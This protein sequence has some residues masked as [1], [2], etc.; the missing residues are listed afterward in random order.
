MSTKLWGGRFTGA[1]DPLME[2][3]NASILFDRRLWQADIRGSQAYA[4]ALA[5]AG[6]LTHVEAAEIVAGLEQ[7]A[8]EWEA[9]E[10]TL[11]PQDEDIHTANERRLTELIGAVAGKLHTGRSRN[12]QIA[13]DVRLWLRDEIATLRGHLEQLIGAT[14]ARAA[15]E[16][17]LLMPGYTHL[18][19]AQPVRW[20]HWLLSHA[21]AWQRDA[22]R[23]DDLTAR[24]NLLPLGSGA[25]AGNPFA[26]DRAAL[27]ADLG[28]VGITPNSLDSVSDRDFIAEFLFWAT[29]TMVHLSRLAEDLIIF[30]SREFGFVTLADAY[31]TGSSLMPQ[32]KNPDAL[33]LLRGKTGRVAGALTSLLVTIKGLPSTYNKD[34]QED[35]EPLFD[36]VTTLRGALPIAC[37]VI[38]TLTPRP[39]RLQAALSSEMLAT[40]LAEYLVRKGVPFRETHHVAGAAVALAESRGAPLHS[41]TAADLRTLHPAFE[42]DVTAVWDFAQS[43]ERRAVAG[44]T[45]RAAVQAQIDQLQAWLSARAG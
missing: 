27:A 20:S 8:A 21:W 18:Q 45:S 38:S 4:R 15:Q 7:V 36:A 33:E 25:L 6:I 24:V 28:F 14:V 19:P 1:T 42:D 17:E 41:L 44:G 22:Q 37:G 32:K 31:S 12:D 23:L 30:S 39:E 29:L 35:K 5:R 9:G 2:Q 10:F 40:D 43:V 16:L 26:I 11:R 13:T 3:F 34:L